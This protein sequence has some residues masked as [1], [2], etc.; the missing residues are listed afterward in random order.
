MKFTMNGEQIEFLKYNL[1]KK[2][3][4]IIMSIDVHIYNTN[5]IM[6]FSIYDSIQLKT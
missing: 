5:H 1:T 3:N 6:T 2:V 4:E